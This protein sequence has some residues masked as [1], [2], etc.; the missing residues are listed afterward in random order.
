MCIFQSTFSWAEHS[1]WFIVSSRQ[2]LNI[3]SLNISDNLHSQK[4]Y[5][6]LLQCPPVSQ[7]SLTN[8]FQY[9][10]SHHT[11]HTILPTVCWWSLVIWAPLYTTFSENIIAYYNLISL[12]MCSNIVDYSLHVRMDCH[13]L[14]LITQI[15]TV[16]KLPFYLSII[17]VFFSISVTLCFLS[18]SLSPDPLCMCAYLY[19]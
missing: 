18:L 16:S 6:R 19:L 10:T 9:Y 17:S 3:Y 7:K 2:E 1:A 15:L 13:V 11:Q 8:S 12:C 4:G 14:F 5:S